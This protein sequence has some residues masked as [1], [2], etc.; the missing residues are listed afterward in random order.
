MRR[1]A[2]GSWAP[3]PPTDGACGLHGHITLTGRYHLILPDPIRHGKYRPLKT[4][5]LSD[6]A[7]P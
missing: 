3:P 1:G 2:G 4:P 7:S 5:D 6:L